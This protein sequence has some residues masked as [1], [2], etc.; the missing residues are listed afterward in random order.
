MCCNII[1]SR[2]TYKESC[3]CNQTLFSDSSGRDW[4]RGY[5]TIALKYCSQRSSSS[6]YIT[7]SILKVVHAWVWDQEEIEAKGN[8]QATDTFHL[9][10]FHWCQVVQVINQVGLRLM[11]KGKSLCLNLTWSSSPKPS[12]HDDDNI[13][14]VF[15]S[16]Q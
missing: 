9:L 2:N 4:G 8:K 5:L 1:P 15:G 3:K 12:L 6:M 14:S 16:Q 11:M 10:T 13:L 7:S